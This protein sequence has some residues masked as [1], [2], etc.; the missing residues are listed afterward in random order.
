MWC[1]AEIHPTHTHQYYEPRVTGRYS[2]NMESYSAWAG[3]SSDYRKKIAIDLSLNT[4]GFMKNNFYNLETPLSVGVEFKPRIRI[5]DKLSFFYTFR[6][7]FEPNNL[8]FADST[9]QIVT[10]GERKLYTYENI[11][12]AKYIF[13]NDL[14]FTVN[15]RHYWNTG[16]YIRYYTLL[17]DGMIERNNNY[18]VNNNF[19]YNAFNIDAVFSWIFAPG[20]VLSIV[21]KNAIEK[22]EQIIPSNFTDDFSKTIIAPQTNSISLKV[23]YYLD[24][25]YL[26]RRK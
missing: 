13:K 20:S 17:E 12:T 14:S 25:Q 3:F 11:L 21:Y 16:E 4:W 7:N 5:T 18:Q 10:Y 9:R 26:K 24:Y 23:V 15:T 1:G 22:D 8:G 2:Y 19:S 6:F